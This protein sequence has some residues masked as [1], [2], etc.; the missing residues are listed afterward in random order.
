MGEDID[1]PEQRHVRAYADL[2]M[3]SYADTAIWEAA[4]VIRNGTRACR[5]AT[6]RRRAQLR[7]ALDDLVTIVKRTG[8]VVAQT[9][10]RLGG[11]MPESSSRLVSLHDPDAR[12]IRKGRLGR[13]VDFGYKA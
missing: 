7:R 13:P 10:S 11:V 9:H 1:S 4:A 2:R 12:P 5:D 3:R 6:G 8:Q